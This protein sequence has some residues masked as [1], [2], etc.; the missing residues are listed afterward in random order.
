MAKMTDAVTARHLRPTA[1]VGIF[2]EERSDFASRAQRVR[3]PVANAAMPELHASDVLRY[4]VGHSVEVS[5]L[6]VIELD[7]GVVVEERQH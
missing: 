7:R 2:N 1:D 5:D 3:M 6:T 4:D